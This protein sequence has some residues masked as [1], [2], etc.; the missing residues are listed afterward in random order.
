[1]HI[2][3]DVIHQPLYCVIPIF[4]PV[5]FKSRWKHLRDF[6]RHIRESGAIPIII[7]AAFGERDFAL[8]EHAPPLDDL[9]H[10]GEFK[11]FGPAHV[12]PSA[13]LPNSRAG[14]DYIKVR[15][16]QQS[17]IWLKE[18]L[19]NIAV[20]HLPE[21][22]KYIAFID[23][24]ITFARPDWVSETLHALQHYDVV[25]MF[26]SAINLSPEHTPL[27]INMGFAY[28]H[29]HNMPH[30]KWKKGHYGG[31]G[32]H[33]P[34]MP[35]GWHT[36]FAWAWRRSALNHVGGLIDFAILGSADNHMARALVGRVE[37]SLNPK[38][39]EGYKTRVRHW[40]RR[41]LQHIKG[42][43]GYIDGT[44]LHAWHG[45]IYNRRYWDR[46]KILIKHG[47]D[48]DS[49]LK[50]DWRGLLALTDQKP[51]LRDDVRRYFRARFEDET[52]VPGGDHRLVGP[53][54][55]GW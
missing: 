42:N 18:N 13:R 37:E 41:A 15:A 39:S 8:E 48:P 52:Y 47:F 6:Q 30:G 14:Q 24:D 33:H 34:G 36:G 9:C 44:I 31:D 50:K 29:W 27:E 28:C 54:P 17:E 51:G 1:M 21:D 49:D 43:I 26:T 46:W 7:E 32:Q 45:R 16:G 35:N 19:Q 5:R 2:P 12:P 23:A 10:N 55:I 4:N 40:Q 53:K 3:K 25:Q 38:L 22:A 20:Q 11:S